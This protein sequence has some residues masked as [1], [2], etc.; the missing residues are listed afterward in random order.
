MDGDKASEAG[1]F[2]DEPTFAMG[3]IERML[4]P[5]LVKHQQLDPF[6]RLGD[7]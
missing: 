5:I 4:V 6:Q 7:H 2:A 3:A 1:V